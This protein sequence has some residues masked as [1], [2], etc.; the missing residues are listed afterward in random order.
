MH[1]VDRGGPGEPDVEG[2]ADVL[3]EAHAAAVGLLLDLGAEVVGDAE[4]GDGHAR[5]AARVGLSGCQTSLFGPGG[6]ALS[7]VGAVRLCG[8]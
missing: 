2:L 8:G 6:V 1:V 4:L 3:A 7:P 5:H